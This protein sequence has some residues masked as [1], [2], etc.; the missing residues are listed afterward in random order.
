MGKRQRPQKQ[1]RKQQPRDATQY[2]N[3]DPQQ[4]GLALDPARLL[5]EP[6]LDPA[7]EEAGQQKQ[8]DDGG[9][10]DGEGRSCG[11]MD[12]PFRG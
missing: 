6:R 12:Q 11:R 8:D 7:S 2:G 9:G 3:D 4:A 1:Q 5:L 10:L